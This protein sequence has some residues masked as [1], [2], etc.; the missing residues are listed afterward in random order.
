AARMA[1]WASIPPPLAVFEGAVPPAPAW[2]DAAIARAPERSFTDVAGVA[3]ETLC[4]GDRGKPG[5]LLMHGN[6]A[7]ADWWSFIAPF[8]AADH[9]VVAFSWSG[10]GRSDHR[11]TYNFDLFVDELLAVAQA[12]GL[13]DGGPPLM[14]GHSF[15]GY[16]MMA[17][18]QRAGDRF[19]AAVIVDT[20]FSD[21]DDPQRHRPPE[22]SGAPHKPNPTLAAAL[23]RFR[24]APPQGCENPYIADHIARHSLRETPEGWVWR[25]DPMIFGRLNVDDNFDLLAGPKCPV[26]LIWG[27]NS[28]LMPAFR[29]A[30]MRKRLPANAPALAIPDAEHHVM[31]D[32]PLAFVAALRG[33]FAGWPG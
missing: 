12:T 2:F 32:Q 9:H 25:F 30:R 28:F 27:D 16:L 6:G 29:V 3:V 18:V 4:W 19:K 10:M 22:R 8:F 31:I 24:L 17:A 21:V 1:G 7:N 23:A 13:F 11:S 15:G 26:A 5:L 33:L 20:P 14:V